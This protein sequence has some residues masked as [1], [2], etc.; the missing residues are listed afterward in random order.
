M[1]GVVLGKSE[2]EFLIN[3][4][5]DSLTKISDPKVVRI[6]IIIISN[7]KVSEIESKNKKNLCGEQFWHSL[8]E[9]KKT[10]N[11][12]NRRSRLVLSVMC[13]TSFTVLVPAAY[14]R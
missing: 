6:I 1:E 9:K 4:G 11:V 10:H 3:L 5:V 12:N 13:V 7:H 2:L 8:C 14:H